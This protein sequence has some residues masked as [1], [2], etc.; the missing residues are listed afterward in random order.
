MPTT[1]LPYLPDQSLLLPAS[2]TD[3]LPE[4]HLAYFISDSVDALG[5]DSFYARYEGDGRRRQ[6]FD[7]HMMVKV[8]VYGYA[9]GVFSSRKIARKLQEDVAFRG[10]GANTFPA[11]GTIREFRQ[12]HLAELSA[13]FVAVVKLAREA[14]LIKLG[15][16]GVD[17]SKIKANASKHKAM[18]Y[19]R[20]QQ[21]EVRLQGESCELLRKAAATDAAEDA[22]HGADRAGT[23][24]PEELDRKEDRLKVIQAAKARP[25]GQAVRTRLG[26][27]AGESP[28]ELHG[29]AGA[30][31]EHPGRLSA[32]LQRPGGSG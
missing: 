27:A 16:L 7:P 32:V 12:L 2:L 31:H 29:S 17:G 23:E 22:E 15:G 25:D 19:G 1:F 6:P 3:W 26:P 5:L 11:H 9:S 18:S 13:L 20:M 21:E 24:L 8:L 4:D 30:D 28:G 14:G 10:L